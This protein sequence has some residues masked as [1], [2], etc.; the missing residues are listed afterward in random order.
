M[1][2][3]SPLGNSVDAA[4]ARLLQGESAFERMQCEGLPDLP[5]ARAS[6]DVSPYL[7]KL[8]Q[9][10]TERVSQMALVAARQAMADA[11]LASWAEPERVGLYVGTGMGGAA[12]MD[13]GYAA[14]YGGSRIH[15]LTVPAG[16]VNGAAA[17]IALHTGVRGPVLTYAVACASSAVAIA[18]AAHALRR[19]EV[20]IALAGGAE[21]LLV[22]G[23][24]AAWHALRALA[25]A[26]EADIARSCRPFAR[27]RSGL[28]LGEG[29]AFLVLKRESD[30]AGDSRAPLAWLAGSAMR[31]DAVH[32][33]NPDARGQ[34]ATLRAA[35]AASQ[36]AP[37]D[38]GY[39]N[40][41][42]TG[43]V[44]GDPVE[45]EALRQVWGDAAP[46]LAFSSTKAAHGHLLGAA[47]ALEAVWT[48]QA[49][50]TGELPPTHGL[51]EIDP[52]CAGL[53]HVLG[54]GMR[55][56]G[57]RHAISNSFAFGGSNTALVFSR[58]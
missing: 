32:L 46:G 15:P 36:L 28:A 22:R 2:I 42:G 58:A 21:A 56:P 57:L 39:C 25:P 19:G 38:I 8:Q 33:T 51:A 14:L 40:A 29:S 45:C 10:G 49:L 1:G 31:C 5:V 47:G 44:A 41:H 23:T 53:G 18:E 24:L 52:A 26:D 16:M 9:V 7:G 43:T 34:A 30:S 27:E 12:T 50:R 3:V 37:A 48:V 11:G 35:L 55:K 17:V 20:D 4:W 6:F 54:P 13:A